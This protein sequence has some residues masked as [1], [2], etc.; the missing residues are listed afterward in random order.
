MS[1]AGRK[2]R[3]R[4]VLGLTRPQLVIV[5]LTGVGVYMVCTLA[6]PATAEPVLGPLTVKD[7]VTLLT[8]LGTWGGLAW[9]NRVVP[10]EEIRLKL[11]D[12]GE[13]PPEV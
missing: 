5:Y 1:E 10:D 7:L 9:R 3:P 6:I 11:V 13:E 12:P 4:R 2:H 8:V